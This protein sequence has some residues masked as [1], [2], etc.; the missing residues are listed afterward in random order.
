LFLSPAGRS[1]SVCAPV[2]EV[3]AKKKPRGDSK[4]LCYQGKV[5]VATKIPIII[6]IYGA[7]GSHSSAD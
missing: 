5:V 1:Y 7:A 6:I 4:D 2:K 3:Q